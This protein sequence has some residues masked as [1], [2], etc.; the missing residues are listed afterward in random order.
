MIS[1]AKNVVRDLRVL[2]RLWVE[3][4]NTG[5]FDS[6]ERARKKLLRSALTIT[7]WLSTHPLEEPDPE[8]MEDE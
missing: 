5:D 2:E 7:D 6:V 4:K 8:E 3:A 1:R